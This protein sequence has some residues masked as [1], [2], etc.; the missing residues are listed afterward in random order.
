MSW[1]LFL[2]I[3]PPDVGTTYDLGVPAGVALPSVVIQTA[4]SLRRS[5]SSRTLWWQ[6]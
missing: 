3:S 2:R 5:G 1:L 6:S 4:V